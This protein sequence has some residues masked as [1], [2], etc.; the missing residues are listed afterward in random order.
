MKQLLVIATIILAPSFVHGQTKKIYQGQLMNY[1]ELATILQGAKWD[2]LVFDRVIFNGDLGKHLWDDSVYGKFTV[3]TP[4]SS[5]KFHAIEFNE[6]TFSTS[7]FFTG[8]FTGDVSITKCKGPENLI[9]QNCRINEL[10]IYESN[11]EII[12]IER[13]NFKNLDVDNKETTTIV[14]KALV[15]S[16]QVSIVSSRIHIFNS[17]FK[18]IG[19]ESVIENAGQGN[20]WTSVWNSRF[21][22]LDSGFIQFEQRDGFIRLRNSNFKGNV[23]FYAD[24]DKVSWDLVDN[25]F[26]A[27]VGFRS[28]A[29]IGPSSYI[30]FD[31]IFTG[32]PLG[33]HLFENDQRIFFDGSG[34]QIG[35]GRHY[36]NLLRLHKRLHNFYLEGGDIQTANLVYNRIKDLETRHLIY[37]YELSPSFDLWIRIGLNKLLKFYTRYGTD[38][39]RAIII[40]LWVIFGFGA[41]YVFFPSSWDVSA[42]SKLIEDLKDLRNIKAGRFKKLLGILA[43]A[44]IAFLNALTLSLNSFVTLGFGEIPTKGFARYLTIAEGFIGWFLLTLFTVALISQSSF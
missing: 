12:Q 21:E 33:W 24:G 4:I 16:G 39:A 43:G 44:T 13:S 38:P 25:T 29:E 30:P 18:T 20:A 1:S 26:D 7:V 14:Y 22:Q 42:K 9:F 5:G 27:R 17:I 40:S 37:Q 41:L 36:L 11:F 31:G 32:K 2:T 23:D 3:S 8:P 35:N 10:S 28:M 19:D 15:D 6:C 34:D